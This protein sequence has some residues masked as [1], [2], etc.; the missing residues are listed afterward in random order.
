M[1]APS[2]CSLAIGFH[3][4]YALVWRLAPGLASLWKVIHE[5]TRNRKI[6]NKARAAVFAK[7]VAVSIRTIAVRFPANKPVLALATALL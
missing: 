5:R 7:V 6:R 1:A 4:T 3:A 2:R